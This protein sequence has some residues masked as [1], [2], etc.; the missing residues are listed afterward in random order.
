M[1]EAS[2]EFH[3]FAISIAPTSTTSALSPH[4][5]SG[6]L[7]YAFIRHARAAEGESAATAAATEL[8]F[9]PDR[10]A[11][12][13]LVLPVGANGSWSRVRNKIPIRPSEFAQHK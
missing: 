13:S 2:Q 12:I 4:P 3:L 11:R 1:N 9:W 7:K 6:P 10:R 5:G 8:S